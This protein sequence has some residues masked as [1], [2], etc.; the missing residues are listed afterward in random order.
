[1]KKLFLLLA[2]IAGA[3][4]GLF[5]AFVLAVWALAREE[6]VDEYDYYGI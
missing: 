2:V 1:M 3:A 4:F 5:Y 6:D